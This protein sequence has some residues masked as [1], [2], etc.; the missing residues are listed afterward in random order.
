MFLK[1]LSVQKQVTIYI[2]KVGGFHKTCI[3][4]LRKMMRGARLMD[5]RRHLM[6]IYHSSIRAKLLSFS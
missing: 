2:H 6:F 3:Y 1:M 4:L 5:K